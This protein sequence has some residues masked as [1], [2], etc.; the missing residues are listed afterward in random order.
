MMQQLQA[1]IAKAQQPGQYELG[2]Q[3]DYNNLN[4][5]INSKDYRN[6]Q[7]SGVAIGMLPLNNYQQ[8]V[9]AGQATNV[10]GV[11]PQS[12]ANQNKVS[13]DELSKDYGGAYEQQV[14][15]LADQRTGMQ[16]QLQSLY[17][18]RMGIG[19]QG[20]QAA[21]QGVAAKPQGFQWQSLIPG[22]A[23]AGLSAA[24]Y[25]A[26]NQNDNEPTG[27]DSAMPPTASPW[28]FNPQQTPQWGTTNSGGFYA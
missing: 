16:S 17:D 24:N 1:S 28:N 21:L 26:G 15:G 13:Q 27:M 11:D 25:F 2:L 9:K 5:F 18:Q 10:P 6:P 23:S 4:N 3:T 14:G 20:Y 8:M 19:V 7:A 22:L 12:L